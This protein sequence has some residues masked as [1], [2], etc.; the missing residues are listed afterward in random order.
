MCGGLHVNVVDVCE[1]SGYCESAVGQTDLHNTLFVIFG[2]MSDGGRISLAQVN[3]AGPVIST[4]SK[5]CFFHNAKIS[6]SS[7]WIH[8]SLDNTSDIACIFELAT[9]DT[10]TVGSTR[11]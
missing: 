2:S 4:L 8:S 10:V 1:C 7:N 9:T 11:L 3:V 5:T 6:C